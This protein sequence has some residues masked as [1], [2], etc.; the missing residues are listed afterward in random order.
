MQPV[1]CANRG[2]M[3]MPEPDGRTYACTYCRT[4]VQVAIDGQQIA[5]GMRL[6]LAILGGGHPLETLETV[7]E[8]AGFE[9]LSLIHI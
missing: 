2:A 8:A 9:I 6:D 4:H 1:P 5:A 7:L 3:M